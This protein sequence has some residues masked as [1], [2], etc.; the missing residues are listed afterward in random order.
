MRTRLL[1]S[2]RV[3][4]LRLWMITI[5]TAIAFGGSTSRCWSGPSN[6]TEQ[7]RAPSSAP[8][9]PNQI[10]KPEVLVKSLS[11][12]TGEKPLVICVGFPVLYQGGHIVGAKFAG[13]AARPAGI[14]ALKREVQDLPRDKQIVLYCGCCPWKRCPNIRPAFRVMQGLGFTNVKVLSIPTN[15]RKDWVDKGYPIE[16]GTDKK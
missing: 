6:D 12:A 11:S 13:P 9:Q 15:F 8:W 2:A 10:V 3:S 5:T 16:K 4:A 14:Q 7:V 1:K